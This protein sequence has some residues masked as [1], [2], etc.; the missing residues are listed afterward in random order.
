MIDATL[1]RTNPWRALRERPL[2]QPP[3][4]GPCMDPRK[5]LSDLSLSCHSIHKVCSGTAWSGQKQSRSWNSL[6]LE[7][8][9]RC[10]STASHSNS[11]VTA[12]CDMVYPAADPV[13]EN[14]SKQIHDDGGTG[15]R[16]DVSCPE[17]QAT[18]VVKISQIPDTSSA[19]PGREHPPSP[20][21]SDVVSDVSSRVP[22]FSPSSSFGFINALRPER[23]AEP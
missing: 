14:D 8:Y 12:I 6:T 17:V 23:V 3:L 7:T 11:L 15:G 9:S 5:L 16:M 10:M 4:Y 18:T 20:S 21:L 1:L 2:R 19:V 13:E 22:I